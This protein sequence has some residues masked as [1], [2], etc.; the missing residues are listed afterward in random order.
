MFRGGIRRICFAI[1]KVATLGRDPHPWKVYMR[2]VL[3]IDD[4][5]RIAQSSPGDL[6][7]LRQIEKEN[8]ENHI[9]GKKLDAFD[10]IRFSVFA[11]LK[12][13]VD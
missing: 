6:L 9:D 8:P 7:R 12:Q 13:D 1:A 2:S 11:D 5:A 10:P 3:R 4:C